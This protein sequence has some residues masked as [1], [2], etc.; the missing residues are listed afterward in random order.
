ME[1]HWHRPGPP[2]EADKAELDRHV[3]LACRLRAH[4]IL[5][6]RTPGLPPLSEGDDV[7]HFIC[8]TSLPVGLGLRNHCIFLQG[9]F[10][11]LFIYL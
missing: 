4:L 11:Y 2:P 10:I 7:L 6:Y 5:L 1:G 8:K 9:V 3:A